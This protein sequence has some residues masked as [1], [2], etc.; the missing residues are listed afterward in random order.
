MEGRQMPMPGSWIYATY[1]FENKFKALHTL[2]NSAEYTITRKRVFLFPC[3][4]ILLGHSNRLT[5]CNPHQP[6]CGV[7]SSWEGKKI[8]AISALPF[9]TLCDKPPASL[10][11]LPSRASSRKHNNPALLSPQR[12]YEAIRVWSYTTFIVN[13]AMVK[14]ETS[15][16]NLKHNHYY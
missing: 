4:K 10:A 15:S 5:L 1:L 12:W 14:E 16:G 2:L 7:R 11:L 6:S 9:S 13:K 8:L 3:L